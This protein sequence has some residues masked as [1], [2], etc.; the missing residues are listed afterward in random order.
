MVVEDCLE[1][2][3]CGLCGDDEW[4]VV[5]G[6]SSRTLELRFGAAMQGR[7]DATCSTVLG[8]AVLGKD[9]RA[10]MSLTWRFL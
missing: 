6:N 4:A 8:L 1:L 3:F 5:E 2:I 7:C 10:G 9:Q